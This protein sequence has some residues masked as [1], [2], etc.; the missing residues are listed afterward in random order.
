VTPDFEKL[1]EQ[2]F[3]LTA[4]ECYDGLDVEV[5]QLMAV[6]NIS[7][8]AGD[9]VKAAV[10][11]RF[12]KVLAAFDEAYLG[13]WRNDAALVFTEQDAEWLKEQVTKQL[14]PRVL[15]AERWCN[16]YLRDSLGFFRRYWEQTVIAARQGVAKIVKK[17]DLLR[18]QKKQSQPSVSAQVTTNQLVGQD[19]PFGTLKIPKNAKAATLSEELR[20]CYANGCWNS[21]GILIGI[22]IERALDAIELKC[23]TERGLSKKLSYCL[24]QSSEFGQSLKD[25]LRHLMAAKVTR[26]IVAHDSAI[27]LDKPDVDIVIPY[28]RHL[29][30]HWASRD[31]GPVIVSTH[32]VLP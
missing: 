32:T 17:I 3:N 23:Q 13:K 29:M 11:G 24:N 15:E 28:F 6:L 26:D 31:S 5:G 21:C 19:D 16:T 1:C 22:L 25:C 10:L 14:D 30:S 27:L 4:D 2:E 9:A 7:T 8:A 20:R 18:L 12:D